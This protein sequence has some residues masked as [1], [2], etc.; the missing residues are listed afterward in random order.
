[1]KSCR[2]VIWNEGMFMIPQ[3]FQQWDHY[4]ESILNF[5]IQ[6]LKQQCWGLLGIDIDKDA[7]ANDRFVLTGCSGVMPDGLVFDMPE[8]DNLPESR[9]IKDFFLP[10]T[11]NMDVYLAIPVERHGRMN[12]DLNEQQSPASSSGQTR[13]RRQFVNVFDETTGGNEKQIG[14]ARKQFRIMFSSESLDELSVI[15]IAELVRA[16]SGNVALKEEFVPACLRI[17]ASDALM[18]TVRQL[19]EMLT[20]KS[21]SLSGERRRQRSGAVEFGSSDI[22]NFWFLHTVNSFIPLISHYHRTASVHPEEFFLTLSQLAGELITFSP[23]GHP[24]ELPPYQHANLDQTFGLLL[25]RLRG[26]LE[27]VLSSKSVSIALEQT[28]QSLFV[29]RIADERL[30]D[31]AQ[32]YLAVSAGISEAD[33]ISRVPYQIKIGSLDKINILVSAGMPGLALYH[34]P[35]PPE[36]IRMQM[37]YHYFRI[38]TQGDYWDVIRQA[39]NLA[40][41]VPSDFTEVKL[42]LI[43]IKE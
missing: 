17:G 30:L 6:S 2:K 32:F 15:K 20:A 36:D 25:E 16:S 27:I 22:S 5:R 29:A 7:L 28:E 4:N 14:I 18:R 19:L 9:N 12:Y 1:M 38:E 35:R 33:I 31:N 41:Y 23:E 34:S 24:G 13:Y 10:S 39:K 43:A 37:G 21:R 26:A 11:E 40:V 3:H 42:D 8:T